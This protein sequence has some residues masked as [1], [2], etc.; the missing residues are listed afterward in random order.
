MDTKKILFGCSII[1]LLT[2][3]GLTH[4]QQFEAIKKING[5]DIFI[6]TAGSGEP[7]V[8]VHGGPGLGH[9]YLYDSFNQLSDRYKLI[10]YDQRGCGKSEE[11]KEEKPVTIDTMVED[12]EAIREEFNIDK[13]NLV[14]QSWGA[15]IALNYI[16]KYPGKVKNL[17]LL[18]PAPGSSEYIQQIQQTIMKR[19]S[20]DEM[21]R[22]TQIA[23][24]PEFKTNPEVFKEFMSIRMNTYFF[25]SSAAKKKKFDYFDNDRVKKFFSSSANFGPYLISF[26]L[27]E[28]MKT[29]NCPT[30]IIHG[31]YDVIP[32]ESIERMGKEIK[33]SEVHIVKDC[34]HFVHIEKPD[35][36]F[37]TI[38]AF[39]ELYNNKSPKQNLHGKY[40]GEELPGGKPILFASG[41]VS[42][43]FFEH[44]SPEF[45]NDGNEVFWTVIP[46][47]PGSEA[48]VKYSKQENGTWSSPQ[49]INFLGG[50]DDMY[51][52]FS[53]DDSKIY[54]SSSKTNPADSTKKERGIWFVEKNNN[55][56]SPAQYIGFDSLDAYGLTVA[57]S[58]NIYFMAQ[59]AGA[60]GKYDLYFSDFSSGK[61]GKPVKLP[62]QINTEYY[63]DNPCL[64]DDE[65]WMIFE[66][67]RPGGFGSTDFY[68]S[69]NKNG[70]WGVPK[71]LGDKI[72]TNNAERFAKFS[73]DK[74]YFFFGS[75][76][77]RGFDI[78]WINAEVI[79]EAA[80]I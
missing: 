16:F 31:D 52:T 75:N 77:Y 24:S 39:L 51:P 44:S 18:E 46:G 48:I 2:I 54:F 26:N 79:K 59:N 35:I 28:K 17:I 60:A 25:D 62:E 14:G 38:H 47:A 6:R 57:K 41:V 15:T 27:Y 72:N 58:G 29:I 32:N 73:R 67:N 50:I 74:K 56:Y 13:M 4:S 70:K 45:S 63:E 71:N 22:L 11:F 36:Y 37:N 7:L 78:Y 5:A 23:R 1:L 76:K 21:E 8:I 12:L 19:L 66:S 49:T 3:S 55:G 33:G 34:G 80:D 69:F 65:S 43:S 53:F 42:T 64:A 30:L 10:F 68:I 9:D 20:K 40:L 61:Y